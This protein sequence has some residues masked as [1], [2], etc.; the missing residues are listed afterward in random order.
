MRESRL[1]SYL[2]DRCMSKGILCLKN[3]GTKGVP[4]RQLIYHGVVYFVELK[5][6]RGKLSM[7]QRSMI[8]K[9]RTQSITAHVVID[10]N[11]I[12]RVINQLIEEVD[13]A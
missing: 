4:D 9:L 5:T 3:T 6:P 7:S 10:R 12:D 2:R 11:D 1:E 8:A 13:N